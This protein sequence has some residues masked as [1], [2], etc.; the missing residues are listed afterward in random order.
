MQTPNP[1]KDNAPPLSP[2]C[3]NHIPNQQRGTSPYI[4]PNPPRHSRACFAR[5]AAQPRPPPAIDWLSLIDSASSPVASRRRGPRNEWSGAVGVAVAC[6]SRGK[7]PHDA[8]GR[9]VWGMR[10][11]EAGALG[12]ESLWPLIFGL[13]GVMDGDGWGWDWDGDCDG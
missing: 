7:G 11:V 5:P 10:E 1:I 13:E 9:P 6:W 12:C 3:R 4:P 8:G 2:K